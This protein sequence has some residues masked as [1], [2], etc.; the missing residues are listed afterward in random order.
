[1]VSKL[2]QNLNKKLAPYFPQRGRKMIS[3]IETVKR[4][5]KTDHVLSNIE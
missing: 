1:M 2:A 3:K 4:R 5:K